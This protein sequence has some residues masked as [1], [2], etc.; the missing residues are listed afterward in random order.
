MPACTCSLAGWD[1]RR[2]S[3]WLTWMPFHLMTATVPRT[4][5]KHAAGKVRA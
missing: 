3:R 2:I 1:P 5:R 4:T